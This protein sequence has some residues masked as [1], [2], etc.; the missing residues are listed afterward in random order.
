[1]PILNV[2]ELSKNFGGVQA[3]SNVDIEVKKGELIGLIGPNGAGKTTIFNLLTGVYTPTS[4]QIELKNEKTG[5][6]I[7]INGLK[8][9]ITSSYG[10]SRTFQNI[11]LFKDLT[12]MDN[13]RIA[14]HRKVKYGIFSAVIRTK[15]FREN[16][17]LFYD[18]AMNI[19]KFVG[20][21]KKVFELADNLPYGE[22]RK[23]EI[24]RAVA[25]G[26]S[27]I[28]LDEPAAGMNPSETKELAK[29]ILKLK[30]EYDLTIIL[31]EHDMKFVMGLCERIYVLDFG[32]II[33]VGPPEEIKNNKRVIE[34]YLGEDA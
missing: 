13:M 1:M 26:A 4:G 32:N 29:L 15:A 5:D 28:F 9:Y 18:N 25:T 6:T 24:A 14:M 3:V 8:P 2:K 23:L 30:K 19:L 27:V 34:A 17:E 11:R 10:I 31:I 12:V 21:D 20:L 16:E 22:Q 33:A 7:N